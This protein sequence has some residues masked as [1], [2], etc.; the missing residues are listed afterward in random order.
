MKTLIISSLIFL[1]ACTVNHGDFT[2]LSNKIVN[3]QDFDMGTSQ[4]IRNIRGKDI[5]HMIIIFPTGNP[6]LSEALNDAFEKTDTDIMTDVTVESWF[7][8]IPYLYGNAGWEVSG[9]AVKTRKN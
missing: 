9:D 1:S 3:T 4:R 7:W 6:K 5:E 2:V 8:W